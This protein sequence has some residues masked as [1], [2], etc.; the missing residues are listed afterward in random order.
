MRPSIDTT[1]NALAQSAARNLRAGHDKEAELIYR[2]IIES[3]PVHR[4]ALFN[5]AQ[6]LKPQ[7]A[8]EAD[9]IERRFLDLGPAASDVHV[10]MGRFL[11]IQGKYA[12]ALSNYQKAIALGD[13]SPELYRSI[14]D[15]HLDFGNPAEA[16]ASYEKVLQSWPGDA[17]TRALMAE[18]YYSL[19]RYDEAISYARMA[20]AIEPT[21]NF[22]QR[23]LAWSLLLLG[24]YEAGLL[25]YENR[26]SFVVREQL[27]EAGIL[28][29]V[30]SLSDKARWQGENLSGKTLLVWAEQG[31]GDNVMMMRYLP[32]LKQKGA[33]S[34]IVYCHPTFVKTMLAVNP[35]VLSTE[36]RVSKDSFDLHCSMLSL[37]YLFG[38]RVETIPANVPYLPLA[39]EAGEKWHKK[40][41]KYSGLKVGI[42]WAGGKKM[43]KDKLRS[44]SLESFAPM[45]AIPGVQFFSLQKGEAEAQLKTV[46][47]RI[48]DWMDACEDYLDTAALIDNLDLVISV[49]TAVVHLAGALG[50]PVWLLNRYESEWRWMADR[51]DS[52]WYPTLRIFRQPA[53]NDWGSVMQTVAVELGQLAEQHAAQAG[54][55]DQSVK[56]GAWGKLSRLW[57]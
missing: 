37:P 10:R 49:D 9:I 55:G 50:K 30:E 6:L 17:I 20:L 46:N 40:L 11:H 35:L 13:R 29:V 26:N 38:T 23:T 14:G 56:E 15:S 48:V 2:K 33:G 32:L 52:P 51:Q 16:L 54:R 53:L 7:H 44:I 19:R 39:A 41:K 24:N 5:L 3:D 28:Q 57:R 47:N 43:E 45:L 12:E 1:P 25:A 31:M 8:A 36:Y 27:D 21:L 18:A 22:S 4:E 42:V 34:V